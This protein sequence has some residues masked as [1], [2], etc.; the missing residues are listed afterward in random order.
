[1]FVV[2]RRPL[3]LPELELPASLLPR[4][5]EPDAFGM[6]GE[7]P[8]AWTLRGQIAF[9]SAALGARKQTFA[10]IGRI[11]RLTPFEK[12]WPVAALVA[13]RILK[14]EQALELAHKAGRGI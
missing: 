6:L 10:E 14:P 8:P 7:S 2:A 11:L 5:G 4:F 9:A 13:L 12:R 3:E 1:M